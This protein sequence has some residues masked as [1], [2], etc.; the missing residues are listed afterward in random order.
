MP[1]PLTYP[2]VYVEEVPSGVRTITGVATSITA[3]IGTALS[4]PVNTPVTINNWGDFERSFGG[5]WVNSYLGYAV[6]HFFLNGGGQ[7][8]IVRVV[9]ANA[10]PATFAIE[11]GF[12][13]E[14]AS[15]GVWGNDLSIVI[16]PVPPNF[17]TSPPD[18]DGSTFNLKVEGKQGNVLERFLNL[19]ASAGDANYLPRVLENAESLVR[20]SKQNDDYLLPQGQPGASTTAA[21]ADSGANGDTPA[22]TDVTGSPADRTGI[23]ALDSVDIFNLLVIPPVVRDADPSENIYRYA[24]EYCHDH[25]AVLLVDAL[26][27]AAFDKVTDYMNDLGLGANGAYAALYFPWIRAADPQR[28]MQVDKFPA[29]GAIAGAIARTDANRGVWKAPAGT[30]ASLN[31]LSGLTQVLTDR[32]NGELNPHAVNCL[33]TFP[34][35]GTVV[36]GARTMRGDD[37][38]ADEYKYLPVRRLAL[39]L[40]ESLYRGLKWV[41]FEPNDEPLWSQIRLNVGAFMQNL[42][43]Q[44]AFEGATPTQAYFVKCDGE[45]TTQNDI[46]LGIVNI[47]VGFAPLKPAEFV[48]LQIQQIAGQIQT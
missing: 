7:A 19:S 39:Y 3:F 15:D 10:A 1:V 14:A 30:D 26:S 48:V 16:E 23:N 22:E 6:Q 35:W 17:A 25:R 29:T 21:T 34:V 44:G 27:G 9:G 37:Q 45:T 43:R 47:V 41:V 31:G 28:A 42:F 2:G 12:Q 5:L 36:W 4:G 32:Q 18:P 8:I 24:A 11:A 46:N 40:E 13:M 20:V 38:Q 33:R